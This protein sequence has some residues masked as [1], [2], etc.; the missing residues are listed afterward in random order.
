MNAPDELKRPE[1]A[2]LYQNPRKMRGLILAG[3]LTLFLL[4]GSSANAQSRAGAGEGAMAIKGKLIFQDNFATPTSYTKQLQ[5]VSPGWGVRTAHAEWSQARDGVQSH[6]KSGHMPVLVYEGTF[7]DAVIEVNFRYHQENGKWGGCRISA[8]NQKLNPRAYA[9]SVWAKTDSKERPGGM[10]L[11]HDEWSPGV[12]TNVDYK[13]GEFKP[14]TWYTLRLELIGDK[15]QATCN[16]VT[17][18]GTHEKFGLMPKTSLW[19]GVGTCPHE[20]RN[21]HIYEATPNPQWNAPVS[22]PITMPAKQ[23]SAKP[24]NNSLATSATGGVPRQQAPRKETTTAH[25]KR[26]I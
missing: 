4:A 13:R 5:P 18:Y 22:K 20:L 25:Q 3:L 15:A 21:V 2:R 7:R 24:K 14:D 26:T 23:A 19:L 17:V 1:R 12:I 6:W 11:E 16:G 10:V 9:A 8:T